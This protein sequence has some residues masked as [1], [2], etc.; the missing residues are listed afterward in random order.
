[1]KHVRTITVPAK[2]NDFEKA[3]PDQKKQ[4]SPC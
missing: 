4:T 3:S 2:A 1:M